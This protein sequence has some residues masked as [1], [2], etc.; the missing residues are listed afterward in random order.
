LRQQGSKNA[1]AHNAILSLD[2]LV[3]IEPAILSQVRYVTF[4]VSPNLGLVRLS[5]QAVS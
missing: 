3:G 4:Y 2:R 5:C 1:N